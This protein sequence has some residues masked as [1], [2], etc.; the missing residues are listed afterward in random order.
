[1]VVGLSPAAVT[2]LS[3]IA[4]VSVISGKKFLDIQ[5]TRVQIHSKCVC[6]M[7][8]THSQFDVCF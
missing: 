5:P 3:D 8:K 7:L 1:M 2:L 6:D 4:P